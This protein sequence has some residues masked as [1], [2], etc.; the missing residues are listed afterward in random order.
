LT[1]SCKQ[2]YPQGRVLF[3]ECKKLRWVNSILLIH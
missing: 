2:T 1:Y 3:L